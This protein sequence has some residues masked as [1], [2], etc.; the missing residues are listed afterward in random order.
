MQPA[1]KSSTDP[2]LETQF[3]WTQ[4]KTQVLLGLLGVILAVAGL[5][6]YRFYTQQRNAAAA[7]LLASAKTQA[8]YEKV[9]SEYPSTAA[10]PS[11]RLLLAGAQ[12]EQGQFAEANAMLQAFIDKNRKH[13]FIPTAKVAMAA[14]LESMGKPDEALE[15][16]R[17][18]AAEYPRSYTAPL[19]LL[20]QV[21]IFKSKGQMDEA[22]RVCETVLTQ[23][24]ESFAASEAT[25]Y[26]RTLKPATTP[27]PVAVPGARVVP[28]ESVAAPLEAAP[29]VAPGAGA[30]VPPVAASPAASAAPSP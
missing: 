3:F 14:N 27:A 25:A 2:L 26:L 22:R 29:S 4:Y 13:E 24:R 7:A 8:E 6:A 15:L 16:Y 9:I 18:V 11:A 19:A 30:S 5:A 17:G 1:T 21:P 23:Y 20:A 28:A 12:R 10:A